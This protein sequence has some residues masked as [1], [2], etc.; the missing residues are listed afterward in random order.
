MFTITYLIK[1]KVRARSPPKKQKPP[2]RTAGHTRTS[3]GESARVL[4]N[5]GSCA[6]INGARV[7]IKGTT[8]RKGVE[9]YFLGDLQNDKTGN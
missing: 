9:I 4:A 5:L 2:R 6:A 1:L 8:A 7:E 3:A